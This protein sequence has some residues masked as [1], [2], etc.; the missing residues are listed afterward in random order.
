MLN[1]FRFVIGAGLYVASMFLYYEVAKFV[2]GDGLAATVGN[3]L[4]VVFVGAIWLV[5]TVCILEVHDN[6]KPLRRDI[7]DAII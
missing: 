2:F 7:V 6:N 1:F 5:L 4:L 3:R